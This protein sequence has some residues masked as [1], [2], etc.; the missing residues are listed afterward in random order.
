MAA[1]TE[2][3]TRSW[4][5]LLRRIDPVRWELPVEAMAGMRVPGLIY[6]DDALMELIASDSAIEQVANVATL[7]GIVGK[8]LALPDV[9]WGYGFPIGGVAATQVQ[10]G[11]VSPGGVG[12]DINCGVRLLRTSLGVQEVLPVL[13]KLIDQL[14]RDVPAGPGRNSRQAL[15]AA[16]EEAILRR[17][18]AAAVELGYGVPADL[19]N[20]ES[21]GT[22]GG[23][24]LE[25][26]SERARQRGRGQLGTLGS[27]NHFLEVQAVDAILDEPGARAFGLVPDQIVVMIHTGSRGL[28]HQACQDALARMQ[29]AMPAY[30]ISVPDRQLACVP[31]L[32]PEGQAYL[33]AM[34]AAANF[35]WANRQAITHAVRQAFRRVLGIPEMNAAISVLYDVAHNIAKI[36]RHT[37]E[38]RLVELCVHRK[39]ATR[40][41]PAGH[42]EIPAAYR[43]VGQPVLIPGDMGRHSYVCVGLPRAMAET[44]GSVCHGAGRA[45]SRTSAKKRLSGVDIRA[46]LRDRGI[47]VRAQNPRA[48]A[49]EASEAYKDVTKVVAVLE[50]AGL[51]RSVARLR[52]LAVVKG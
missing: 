23:A 33:G 14:F 37:F 5:D 10:D 48:L 46:Q 3:A 7:P 17:G 30:G 6:A 32:S 20:L 16:D 39:G 25:Q 49:E 24:E 44:W 43:G 41:F 38:D 8:S 19:D 1:A 35:A 27:G 34:A 51:A 26:V 18:A 40:A 36:E 31:V 15:S 52:P 12:F 22:L 47:V 50:R 13:D 21:R 29:T 11:V 9:H 42:P 45:L 2:T 4:R 28:G